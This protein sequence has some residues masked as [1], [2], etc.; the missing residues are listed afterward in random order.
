MFRLGKQKAKK[1]QQ[2]PA[3]VIKTILSQSVSVSEARDRKTK[4]TL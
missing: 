3:L 2:I 4:F 1:K